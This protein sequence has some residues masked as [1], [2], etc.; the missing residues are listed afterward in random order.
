MNVVSHYFRTSFWLA[1]C[2]IVVYTHAEHAVVIVPWLTR[3]IGANSLILVSV[4]VSCGGAISRVRY[5]HTSCR[6]KLRINLLLFSID[7]CKIISCVVGTAEEK[8]SLRIGF[9]SCNL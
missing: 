3:F 8:V 4:S 2:A 7:M 9:A 1:Q 6:C 5:Q